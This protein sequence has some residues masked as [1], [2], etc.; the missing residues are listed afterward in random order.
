M[1]I[2]SYFKGKSGKMFWL[3]VLLMV[4]VLVIVP[5]ISLY[6]L[7]V[8]T[9]H[10]EKIEVA[11]VVGQNVF[12]AEIALS[13]QGLEPVVADSVYESDKPAGVVLRQVPKAGH[14][15]KSGRIVYLTKNL[16]HE[17][18]VNIPDLAGNSSYR[19]AE[20]QL[21]SMGFTLTPCERVKGEPEDLVVGVK[22]NGRKLRADERISKRMPLTLCVGAGFGEDYYVDAF[23]EEE[24]FS[25]SVEID[26]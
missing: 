17:P 15:V 11:D 25:D 1:G 22:Q 8:F 23:E 26:F 7:D 19:E 14:E 4:A 6:C 3:N 20:A 13:S 24:E 9:H 18:L 2:G 12:D 16:D 21:K 5:V 10:G